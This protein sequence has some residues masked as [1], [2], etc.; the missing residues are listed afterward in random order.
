Q[1]GLSAS[2]ITSH[3][4]TKKSFFLTKTKTSKKVK[5]SYMMKNYGWL[6]KTLRRRNR[7]TQTT[8]KFIPNTITPFLMYTIPGQNTSTDF[9]VL[10]PDY[11][12]SQ[13]RF[14]RLRIGG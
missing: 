12:V 8:G 14:C 10:W 1:I 13:W 4:Q 2:V 11:R 5:L 9:V 6:N 3:L 7:L